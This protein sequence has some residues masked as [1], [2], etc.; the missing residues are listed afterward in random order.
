M[1][2]SNEIPLQS[3]HDYFDVFEFI[4]ILKLIDESFQDTKEII[5]GLIL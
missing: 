5:A 2:F 3:S 4:W 1:I